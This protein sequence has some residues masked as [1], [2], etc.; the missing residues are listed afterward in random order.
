VSEPPAT[1]IALRDRGDRY[2]ARAFLERVADAGAMRSV[3]ASRRAH[4]GL[5]ASYLRELSSDRRRQDRRYPRLG[6]LASAA[7]AITR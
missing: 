3:Q 2:D 1:S 4:A 6:P 5:V 7:E